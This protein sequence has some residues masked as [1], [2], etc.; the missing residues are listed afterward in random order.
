MKGGMSYADRSRL[1]AAVQIWEEEQREYER[2]KKE[3]LLEDHKL[4]KAS[5][6][7]RYDRAE[8]MVI[9]LKALKNLQDFK[10]VVNVRTQLL[11][12]PLLSYPS[13]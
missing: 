10:P 5:D 6:S 9:L 7:G 13:F 11:K 8:E 3:N 12:N 4:K 2:E 1:D